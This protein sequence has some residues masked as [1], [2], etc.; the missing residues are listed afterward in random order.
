MPYESPTAT[1]EPVPRGLRL[2]RGTTEEWAAD[3]S[4]GDGE[5]G[6]NS[7][8]G[9]IRVG[10][11][12]KPWT[13]LPAAGAQVFAPAVDVIRIPAGDFISSSGGSTGQIGAGTGNT[14]RMQAWLLD[15]SSYEVVST[16]TRNPTEW[17]AFHV[18]VEWSNAGAGT[19]DVGWRADMLQYGDGDTI[20]AGTPSADI[21]D[22]APV[23]YIIA[24]TRLHASI[25]TNAAKDS[26]R[27][28]I[29]RRAGLA[30]DTLAN[31]AGMTGV[32]LRRSLAP[33][34]ALIGDSIAA[35]ATGSAGWVTLANRDSGGR[36]WF[37]Q[38][39]GVGGQTTDYVLNTEMPLLLAAEPD[40]VITG[41]GINDISWETPAST[42]IANYQAIYSQL[43]DAGITFFVPV[44]TPSSFVNTAPEQAAWDAVN[45]W[46]RD[47]AVNHGATAVIDW[48]EDIREPDTYVWKDGLATDGV[49]PNNTGMAAMA[50]VLADVFEANLSADV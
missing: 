25:P 19:G 4:L 36:T 32:L 14:N 2:R 13:D 21:F 3:P 38:N 23:Q 22:A 41:G 43:V 11:G 46:I 27:L 33:S 49:H 45:A 24:R 8:T 7:T 37:K 35:Q 50:A 28:D 1:T 47:E 10:D 26:I 39:F 48:D 42:I 15:A 17:D 12:V 34:L 44:L 40:V 20:D 9:E 29:N 31:D 5:P 18:E 16:T 30:G 6:F